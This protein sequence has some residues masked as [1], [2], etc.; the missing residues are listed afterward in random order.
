MTGLHTVVK[1]AGF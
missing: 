1:T